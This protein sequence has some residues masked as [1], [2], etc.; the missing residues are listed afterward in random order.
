M[1]D[2][3]LTRIEEDAKSVE[4][5]YCEIAKSLNQDL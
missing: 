3:L 1:T 2:K 4:M 5:F